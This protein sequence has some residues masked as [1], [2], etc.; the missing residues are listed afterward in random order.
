MFNLGVCYTH[1]LNLVITNSSDAWVQAVSLFGY[2]QE[3]SN[4]FS[5]S[6]K[7]MNIFKDHIT[8][9]C[10][11]K[12]LEKIGQTRWAIKAR[13]I[14]KCFCSFIDQSQ[15]FLFFFPFFFFFLWILSKSTRTSKMNHK[16]YLINLVNMRQS[17]LPSLLWIILLSHL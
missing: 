5:E 3:L 13:P 1:D 17:S 15:E 7:K 8:K 12:R 6:C 10:K 16:N 14:N 2:L 11:L 4:F 9:L